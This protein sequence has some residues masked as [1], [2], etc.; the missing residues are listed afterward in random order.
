MNSKIYD[1]FTFYQENFITNLRF[2]ILNEF[3]D[4]FVVCESQYD[5]RG[6]NKKLNFKLLNSKFKEKVI[7]LVYEGP[8]KSKNNMWENQAEQREHIISG[9]S[10]ASPN[11]YI[12]FSDPD[13]I[14]RP[15]LLKNLNLKKRYGIFLQN[16]YCYKFNLF[17][18]YESPWEGTRVCKI[19]DLKSIDYMRQKIRHKN[20]LMPFWKF[21]REKNIEVIENGG[22]HFNSLL[23]PEEISKKL[24]T[25]AHSEYSGEKYSS[26]ESIKKKIKNKID[27]FD[28]GHKYEAVQIDNSF[29]EYLIQNIN[30]FS[31]L[32]EN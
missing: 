22:W 31:H 25:F 1:C 11:D 20:L 18:K 6:N 19:K 21:Y 26:I 7:Y 30:K 24:K 23:S 14:P 27:L 5:H 3:V 12:M 15:D 9:L 16:I 10:D 13:E 2:E 4:Y 17:N 32:I 29:P 8:F 28:R